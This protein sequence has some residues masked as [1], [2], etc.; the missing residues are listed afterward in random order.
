MKANQTDQPKKEP[1][2]GDFEDESEYNV[3]PFVCESSKAKVNNQRLKS[4][5][6]FN[7]KKKMND[8]L[9]VDGHKSSA[10]NDAI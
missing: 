9:Y 10:N 2:C 8:F 7:G 4:N 3:V 6:G 1:F 5:R